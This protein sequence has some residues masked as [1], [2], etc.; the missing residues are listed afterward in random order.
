MAQLLIL[1]NTPADPTAYYHHTH[2]P[3]LPQRAV[4][5]RVS[6]CVR[7]LSEDDRVLLGELGWAVKIEVT[8]D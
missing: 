7:E 5:H 1:Y 6:G 2:I 8:S 4:K 3:L